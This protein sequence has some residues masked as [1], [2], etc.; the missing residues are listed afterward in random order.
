VATDLPLVPLKGE[1]KKEKKENASP[2]KKKKGKR[3]RGAK[4]FIV[5]K[6]RRS[7]PTLLTWN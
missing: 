2:H 1:G 4:L 3:G 7:L 5:E 6:R